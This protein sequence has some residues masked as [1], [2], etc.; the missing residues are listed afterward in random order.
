LSKPFAP[1][2]VL[3]IKLGALGDFVQAT[4][5][6]AAIRRHHAAA[7]I[8]LLTTPPFAEL[9]A[10]SGWFDEVWAEGRPG[11]RD[12]RGWLDLR[13]RLRGGG[14]GRVYDLQT[15]RRSSFYLRLFWPGPTPE[16]SG[17]AGDCSH[18]HANPRRDFMHTLERQAEQLA[19]AGVADVPPSDFSWAKA[20]LDRFTL[21]ERFGLVVPGGAVHRPA[22]R[23]PAE[24]FAAAAGWL[25]EQGIQP[26]L[27]GAAEETE[28]I[29]SIA[30]RAP[31]ARSLAG[32]TSLFDI[33]ALAR[34]A[35]VALGN[36]TG[37]MH[38]CALVG[39]PSVVLYSE[40]S[41]PALCAQ[42]GPCVTILRRPR[43]AH[44]EVEEVVSALTLAGAGIGSRFLDS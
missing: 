12:L 1:Q 6:F 25:A 29:Q 13:R 37:P 11:G 44:L 22:K 32:G 16:W 14:F 31:G 8:T 10:A 2:N 34:G 33:V 35:A 36:D 9:A 19:V 20:D 26:V 43:L 27:L 41:D 24:R 5:P 4:G 30:E 17:I 15:S 18:P 38:V 21:A 39:C 23:W 28:L 40:A 3:V 42:R 7:R